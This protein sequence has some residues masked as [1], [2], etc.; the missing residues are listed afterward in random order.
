MTA[1]NFAIPILITIGFF[2]GA[3]VYAAIAGA[4][5]VLGVP[6]KTA[7]MIGGWAALILS[8]AVAGH[9]GKKR[10]KGERAEQWPSANHTLLAVGNI[11]AVAVIVVPGVLSIFNTA[12]GHLWWFAILVLPISAVFWIAGFVGMERAVAKRTALTSTNKE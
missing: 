11:A 12:Y 7:E 9:M 3:G 6:Q 1:I 2:V 4:L 10:A 8:L 5:D